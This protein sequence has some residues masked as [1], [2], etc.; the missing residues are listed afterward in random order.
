MIERA[1]ARRVPKKLPL[2]FPDP[3]IVDAGFAPAHQALLVELPVLVT[4]GTEPVSG[5]VMPFV[6]ETHRDPVIGEGPQ[7]LDQPV[8]MLL[9]PFSAE[10]LDDRGA[11]L[12][13]LGAISPDA[14]FGVGERNLFRI[15]GISA[16]FRA[17]HLLNG[18]LTGE[19]R[20]RWARHDTLR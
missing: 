19:G 17:A 14:V 16:I 4:V 11:A 20:K 18:G 3:D 8:L 10:E 6:L 1:R 2:V 5:I 7:F 9:G 13:K 12:K 15:A